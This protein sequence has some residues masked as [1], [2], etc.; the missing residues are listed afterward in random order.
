MNLQIR[1]VLLIAPALLVSA[2]PEPTAEPDAHVASAVDAFV[3]EGVDAPMTSETDAAMVASGP[4]LVSLS[5]GEHTTCAVLEDGTAR[6]WGSN[7]VGQL[8]DGTTTPSVRPV[9]VTGITD[10]IQISTGYDISC[11]LRSGGTV[12]CWGDNFNGRLGTGNEDDSLV[13]V[14]VMG[15][16]NVTQ[17]VAGF[18]TVCAL[19]ERGDVYCWGRAGELGDGSLGS[20]VP[21]P[22]FGL[23]NVDLLTGARHGGT[24]LSSHTCGN[25]ITD[26]PFCWGLNSDGQN[27]LGH[28]DLTREA[29]TLPVAL[30]A[31]AMAVGMNHGCIATPTD[32]HCFG[33]STLI[34]DGSVERRFSPTQVMTSQTF[35]ALAAGFE[36]TCGLTS[37]GDVWCWGR[38]GSGQIGDGEPLVIGDQRLVPSQADVSDVVLL[39]AGAT[40]TCAHTESSVTYCWG[41]NEYGELGWGEVGSASRTN[42]PGAVIW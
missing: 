32:T 12:M 41:R 11:V 39:T 6:C 34:G 17:I 22:V 40:H 36:H 14:E 31:V 10:A 24:S 2:C 1:R 35:T 21:V 33:A 20:N 19:T 29:T 25:S 4:R 28:Q 26:G 15:L 23:E 30:D 8:G 37:T 42:T 5:A 27:G 16:T 9:E 3:P 13:P 18:S 7:A 38:N